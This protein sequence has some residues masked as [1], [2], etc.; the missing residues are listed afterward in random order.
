[1]FT[2]NGGGPW[3]CRV[4]E[5]EWPGGDDQ[6]VVDAIKLDFMGPWGDRKLLC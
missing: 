3:M 1:M 2:L 4:P 5:I 6:E